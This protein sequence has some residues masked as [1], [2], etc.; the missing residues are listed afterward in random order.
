MTSIETAGT[1]VKLEM[2]VFTSFKVCNL[3]HPLIFT[4]FCQ[5][6]NIQ[7]KVDRC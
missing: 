1:R 4:E 2:D 3:I 7:T 5:S 6:E